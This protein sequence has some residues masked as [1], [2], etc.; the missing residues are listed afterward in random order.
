[1]TKFLK[2]FQR[3]EILFFQ[4]HNLQA[5]SI[6][7][8]TAEALDS[9]EIVTQVYLRLYGAADTCIRRY[10][11]P[12]RYRHLVFVFYMLLME[13]FPNIID[14]TIWLMIS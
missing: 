14:N 3:R 11:E 8:E 5:S 12:G 4:Y 9:N 7:A 2:Q 1:M 10:G 6:V 13:R